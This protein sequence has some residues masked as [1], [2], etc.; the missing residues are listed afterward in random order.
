MS[1]SIKHHLVNWK[2][3]KCICGVNF[4]KE[5]IHIAELD[6]GK[7]YNDHGNELDVESN[8]E[9]IF[10][11][12]CLKL[13]EINLI[14]QFKMQSFLIK[15]ELALPKSNRLRKAKKIKSKRNRIKGI[16]TKSITDKIA[17]DEKKANSIPKSIKGIARDKKKQANS[18]KPT[19]T[20]PKK[21]KKS[22]PIKA[23]DN[24]C[25]II[26]KP[27]KPIELTT[28]MEVNK[29][30]IDLSNGPVAI[31]AIEVNPIDD[32][33]I[34]DPIDDDIFE[35]VIGD[36]WKLIRHDEQLDKWQF[37]SK[38]VVKGLPKWIAD[39][40]FI[41]YDDASELISDGYCE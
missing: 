3:G 8:W 27:D 6:D 40:E 30:L 24:K 17:I 18:I 5:S 19:K 35:L 38:Q 20:I 28:E 1:K 12:S 26:S 36:D 32:W 41:S 34:G 23:D 11:M 39:S 9:S 21:K 16:K 7:W 15:F 14:E 4:K 33:S 13:H 2:S 29:P 37:V 10:C 31:T 22:N 25:K